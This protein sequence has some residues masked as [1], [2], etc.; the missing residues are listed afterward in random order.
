MQQDSIDI[1]AYQDPREYLKSVLSEQKKRNPAFRLSV[2]ARSSG[3]AS[4]SLLS[5]LMKGQRNLAPT[6]AEKLAKS[7][8]LK[9][10]RK[11]YFLE[12]AR[13]QNARTP[14]EKHDANENM[15]VLKSKAKRMLLDLRHYQ[16]L[17]TWY[18][19][20]LYVMAGMKNVSWHAE[21]IAA[22]LGRGVSAEQVKMAI[23]DLMNLGLLTHEEGKL[24]RVA[25]N[26]ST[27]EHLQNTAVRRYHKEM[28][29]LAGEAL[30]EALEYREV[31][32]LTVAIPDTVLPL[33][34]EK[35]RNFRK[36][37]NTFLSQYEEH[38]DD[39]YQIN[40]QLFALTKKTLP[41]EAQ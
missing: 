15:L 33:V 32:G 18:Y 10:R 39:V 26:I 35:I 20:V 1:F 5:M 38:A 7:L 22:K 9:G 31:N 11:T 40:F 28:N 13:S 12:M 41:E 23:A 2:F 34:K 29:R 17:S 21:Q 3:F 8:G 16:F 27:E 14:A 36:E 6:A 37:L 4:P 24:N 19:P 30:D 25:L